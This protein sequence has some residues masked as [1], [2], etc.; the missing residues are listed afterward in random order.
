MSNHSAQI[1]KICLCVWNANG[2]SAAI[3]MRLMNAMSA[4]G[5][6]ATI[7]P[8][9]IDAMIV[10]AARVQIAALTRGAKDAKPLFAEKMAAVQCENVKIAAT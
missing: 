10:A 9:S 2:N 4:L 5:P 7:A 3:A 6:Y 1:A 8:L